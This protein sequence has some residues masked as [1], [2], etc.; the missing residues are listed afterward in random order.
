LNASQAI[1]VKIPNHG[2]RDHHARAT[3]ERLQEAQPDEAA[4][5]RRQ[6]AASG[7]RHIQGQPKIQRQLAAILVGNRPV[8]KLADG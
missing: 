7:S 4:D 3:T 6:R 1:I 2:P 8:E 5:V